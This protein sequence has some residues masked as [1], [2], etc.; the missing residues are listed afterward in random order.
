MKTII[1]D[2]NL[3]YFINETIFLSIILVVLL[4]LF[5]FYFT[6]KGLDKTKVSLH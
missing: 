1:N 3:I 5:I 6:T 2:K 4:L